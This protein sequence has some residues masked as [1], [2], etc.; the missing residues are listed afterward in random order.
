MSTFFD[1][2]RLCTFVTL[3][4]LL[5]ESGRYKFFTLGY[6]DFAAVKWKRLLNG[7]GCNSVVC[8]FQFSMWQNS[9]FCTSEI[10]D[11][12]KLGYYNSN[13]AEFGSLYTRRCARAQHSASRIVS[14]INLPHNYGDC[15]NMNRAKR[16]K[17]NIFAQ[18]ACIT[19]HSVRILQ[20]T[21]LHLGFFINAQCRIRNSA[22]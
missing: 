4:R 18:L 7:S 8:N 20:L 1:F 2:T 10:C 11:E 15:W 12:S 21:E 6:P 19:L 16:K 5:N 14:K 13:N 3:L 9:D 17:R 22:L